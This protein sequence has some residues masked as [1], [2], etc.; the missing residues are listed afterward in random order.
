MNFNQ[1]IKAKEYKAIETPEGEIVEGWVYPAGCY[2]VDTDGDV[3]RF[4]LHIGNN[5]YQSDDIDMLERILWRGWADFE[6]N[7]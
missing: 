6:I 3:N 7:S 1:F 5:E 4:Y 2:I